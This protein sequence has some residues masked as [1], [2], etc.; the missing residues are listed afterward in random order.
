VLTQLH[1]QHATVSVKHS[2]ST[3]Y[4][5]STHVPVLDPINT[6]LF[7]HDFSNVLDLI[8]TSAS[9]RS[10][11]HYVI[12]SYFHQC[13]ILSTRVPVLDLINTVP[14]QHNLTKSFRSPSTQLS[15]LYQLGHS[16][17]Q[18]G[19]IIIPPTPNQ[20]DHRSS[21]TH[22]T[23]NDTAPQIYRPPATIS[24]CLCTD[25]SCRLHRFHRCRWPASVKSRSVCRDK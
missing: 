11:Q 18:P 9:V 22:Q 2:S 3:S 4:I 7:Q 23:S 10:C 16:T 13:Q 15:A 1:Q 21:N 6:V 25:L 14:F 8:N 24:A 20:C 5:L 12:S 19:G 17:S